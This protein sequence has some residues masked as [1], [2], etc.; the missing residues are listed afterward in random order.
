M[1]PFFGKVYDFLGSARLALVLLV[2]ILAACLVGVLFPTPQAGRTAVFSSLWFNSLLV[3]L[4]VNTAVCFFGSI[5]RRKISVAFFGRIIFHLSFLLIFIGIVYNSLFY[6]RGE[7]RLTEGES[8]DIS[9]PQNYDAAEWGLFFDH[10]AVLKGVI[11]FHRLE[12]RYVVDGNSKGVAN[13]ITIAEGSSAKRE[14]IYVTRHLNFGGLKFYR[15]KD[16]FSPLIVMR[17]WAGNVIYGAYSP[18]Q[19]LKKA[20]KVYSYTTG[21]AQRPGPIPF[22]QEPE[23][24]LFNLQFEYHPDEKKDRAGWLFFHIW[25]YDQHA[26][27]RGKELFR[28][29]ADF[30]QRVRVGKYLLSMEEVRFWAS[31]TMRYSPGMPIILTSFWLGLGGL[32]LTT[33]ARFRKRD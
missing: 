32:V 30:G 2:L 27:Q 15:N 17:D 9:K 11:T 10:D 8:L 3:A 6:F 4:V 28:G 29:R 16:G 19:S 26:E 24:S 7:I 12:P 18:I 23:P 22:P 14:F 13:E 1:R 33:V 20:E 25:Q 21:T 5:W 31:M